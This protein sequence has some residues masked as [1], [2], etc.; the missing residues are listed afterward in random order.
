MELQMT[1][2]GSSEKPPNLGEARLK[3]EGAREQHQLESQP[4]LATSLA[5]CLTFSLP[6]PLRGWGVPALCLL[7]LPTLYRVFPTSFLI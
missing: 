7:I 4:G 2:L 1:V 5:L 6:P 3:F